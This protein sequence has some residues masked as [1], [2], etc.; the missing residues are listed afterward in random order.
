MWTGAMFWTLERNK[1][2]IHKYTSY[3]R[4]THPIWE[5]I[6]VFLSKRALFVGGYINRK[7]GNYI[8]DILTLHWKNT[9]IVDD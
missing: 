9:S 8:V 4:N 2:A 5:M 3:S 6:P 7:G 1:D